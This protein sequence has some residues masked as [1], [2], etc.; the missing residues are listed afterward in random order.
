MFLNRRVSRNCSA[1]FVANR[2]ETRRR[3]ISAVSERSVE[4][5]RESN[6]IQHDEIETERAGRK[7]AKE[8]RGKERNEAGMR[9]RTGQSRARIS[10]ATYTGATWILARPGHGFVGTL[11]I[12]FRSSSRQ[13]FRCILPGRAPPRALRAE[14]TGVLACIRRLVSGDTCNGYLPETRNGRFERN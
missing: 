1:F 9:A 8:E 10:D 7:G 4:L 5:A 6:A 14:R 2:R 13:L 3:G 11:K 12:L